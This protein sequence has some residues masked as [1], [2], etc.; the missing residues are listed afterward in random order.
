MGN[1]NNNNKDKD[2]EDLV[3]QVLDNFTDFNYG[4][5][6]LQYKTSLKI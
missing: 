2:L 4:D 1:N 5:A 6:I 3:N